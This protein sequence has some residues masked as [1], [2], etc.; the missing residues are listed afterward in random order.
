VERVFGDLT[1]TQIRRGVFRSVPEL[2]AAI[3]AYTTPRNTQPTPFVWTNTAQEI[4][5]K[6]NRAR[7]ALDKTRTA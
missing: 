6:V 5:A 1:A 4:L 7:I 3:D 2:I